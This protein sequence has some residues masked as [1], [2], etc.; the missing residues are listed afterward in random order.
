VLERLG[1]GRLWDEERARKVI[2]WED[3]S[4]EMKNGEDR[5]RM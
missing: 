4:K 5:E 1:M 3:E 2:G